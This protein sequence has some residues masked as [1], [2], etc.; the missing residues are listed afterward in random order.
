MQHGTLECNAQPNC[1]NLSVAYLSAS[2]QWKLQNS[3]KQTN[4][5][6][7]ASTVDNTARNNLWQTHKFHVRLKEK[8]P[9]AISRFTKAKGGKKQENKSS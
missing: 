8:I 2:I 7:K 6:E 1:S 3:C 9:P 5:A 4:K